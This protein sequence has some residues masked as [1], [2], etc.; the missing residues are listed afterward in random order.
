MFDFSC[1]SEDVFKIKILRR[2]TLFSS[3]ITCRY[4]SNLY[5]QN[6]LVWTTRK[7]I[8]A[9]QQSRLQQHPNPNYQVSTV[10]ENKYCFLSIT[11]FWLQSKKHCTF[12]S[13]EV[14]IAWEMFEKKMFEAKKQN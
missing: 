5:Y 9:K 7:I 13:A 3:I 4:G 14:R 10:F 2:G 8:V 6:T 1:L 12:F 11:P